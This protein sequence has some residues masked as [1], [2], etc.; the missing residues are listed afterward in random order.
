M[1]K[2]PSL[3]PIILVS[4]LVLLIFT[5]MAE[6]Q[7]MGADGIMDSFVGRTSGWWNIMRDAAR[8]LFK[9][10]TIIEICLFGIRMVIQRSQIETIC[11]EFVMVLVYM[12]FIWM[13]IENYEAWSKIV[14]LNGLKPLAAKLGGGETFDVGLPSAMIFKLYEGIAPVMKGAGYSDFGMIMLYVVCMAAIVV[15]FAII[16][17]DYILTICEF[18]FS[19]NVGLILIGLG[20]SKLFEDY[21]VNVMKYVLSLGIKIFVLTLIL[22]IGFSILQLKNLASQVGATTTI[23]GVK[24]LDLLMLLFQGIIL[25]GL[26]KSLPQTCAGLLSGASIGGGNP[27]QGM[28]KAVGAAAVGAATG[29][30][31]LAVKSAINAGSAYMAAGADGTKGLARVKQAA[32]DF[33]GAA[34]SSIAAKITNS[35]SPTSMSSQLRSLQNARKTGI[36]KP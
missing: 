32:K 1:R 35:G 6:A 5:T 4:F 27:L 33:G 36:D 17:L 3:M 2:I 9:V 20:G 16:C 24:V 10:T 26:A 29:G 31:G 23:K 30:A 19:A 8:Q 15:V 7:P 14:A 13:V 11:A 18:H 34:V 22:N 21:A 28:A 25:L 12:I